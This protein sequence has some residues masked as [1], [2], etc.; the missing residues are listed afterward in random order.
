MS[1]PL[2]S[3]WERSNNQQIAGDGSIYGLCQTEHIQLEMLCEATQN[4]ALARQNQGKTRHKAQISPNFSKLSVAVVDTDTFCLGF[5][6][7]SVDARTTAAKG[8]SEAGGPPTDLEPPSIK[9]EHRSQNRQWP[10][11]CHHVSPKN[12]RVHHAYQLI[13]HKT[14]KN[15]Q[16]ILKIKCIMKL[17][18]RYI[19]NLN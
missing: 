7:S 14:Y 13:E 16:N 5:Q 3:K 11:M 1:L 4:T 6:R 2:L 15:I 10:V 8:T 9:A 19:I 18:T 12:A 17:K